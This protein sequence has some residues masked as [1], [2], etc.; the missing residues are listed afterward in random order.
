[1][2][3]FTPQK[4]E[5]T[6]RQTDRWSSK[7]WEACNQHTTLVPNSIAQNRSQGPPGFKGEE[8]DLP[9]LGYRERW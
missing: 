1:M 9:L 6:D 7:A 8:L 5:E 4:R 2:S 3:L